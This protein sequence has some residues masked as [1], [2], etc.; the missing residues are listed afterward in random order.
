MIKGLIFDLD[1]TT[2]NTLLDMHEC[3][4][5]T[6]RDYG[7]QE[8]TIDEVRLGVGKGYRVLIQSVLPQGSSDELID[9]VTEKYKN[10]YACGYNVK[11]KPYEGVKELLNTLQ[12]KGYLLAVNSNKGNDITNELTKLNFP[13]I[14][15]VDIIGS[16]PNIPNKPDPT[17]ANEI[18]EKMGLKK[19]E[20]VYVGDSE[21]DIKTAHNAGLK[22]IGCTY[23]FRDKQVLVEN[24]AD[25]T[26]D[27]ALDLLKVL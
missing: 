16:R 7:F 17:S 18:I 10:Y 4:N 21:S 25:I 13:E 2:L 6:M 19:E 8:K 26:I 22:C 23:G 12:E 24:G 1:G 27:T 15:F 14:K 20:V 11:T 3:I 5:K 9:E